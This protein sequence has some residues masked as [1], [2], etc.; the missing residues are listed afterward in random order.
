MIHTRKRTS[1][2]TFIRRWAKLITH[3]GM[4]IGFSYDRGNRLGHGAL[5]LI[6]LPDN[7]LTRSL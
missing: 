1:Q 6:L 7:L 3:D 5:G 4:C 2:I